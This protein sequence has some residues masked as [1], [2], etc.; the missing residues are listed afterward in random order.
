MYTSIVKIELNRMRIKI[1]DMLNDFVFDFGYVTHK[2]SK[3][4]NEKNIDGYFRLFI[5][6]NGDLDVISQIYQFLI[7]VLYI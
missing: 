2:I 5:Y 4:D 6:L 7:T 3:V 1:K